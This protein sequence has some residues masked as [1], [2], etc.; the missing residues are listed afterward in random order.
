V[1]VSTPFVTDAQRHSVIIDRKY[2]AGGEIDAQTYHFAAVYPRL[3]QHAQHDGTQSF[4]IVEWMLKC[5]SRR[6]PN[7]RIRWRQVIFYD[8]MRIVGYRGSDFVS[9]LGAHQ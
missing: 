7:V 4:Q 5:P 2:G 8:A 9:A 1:W 6:H 3:A